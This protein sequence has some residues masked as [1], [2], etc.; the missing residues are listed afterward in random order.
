[1]YQYNTTQNEYKLNKELIIEKSELF[2]TSCSKIPV[3]QL[4]T[5]N[6][7]KEHTTELDLELNGLP[8]LT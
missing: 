3:Q 5:P 1:M 7:K 4:K 2:T 8:T 6:A